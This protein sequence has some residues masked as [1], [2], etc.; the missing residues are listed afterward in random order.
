MVEQVWG[1]NWNFFDANFHT[2]EVL[3]QYWDNY[4]YNLIFNYDK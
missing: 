4:H 2:Q 3:R 1:E